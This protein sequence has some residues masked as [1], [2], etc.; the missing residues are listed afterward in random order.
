MGKEIKGI[1]D[2]HDDWFSKEKRRE[3][4]LSVWALDDKAGY[5]KAQHEEHCEREQVRQQHEIKHIESDSWKQQVRDY[6]R[7]NR[8]IKNK[9]NTVFIMIIAVVYIIFMILSIFWG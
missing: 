8:K 3:E 6:L 1:Q 2:N 5:V 9:S 4:G 7:D